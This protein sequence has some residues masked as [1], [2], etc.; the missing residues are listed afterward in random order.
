[1]TIGKLFHVAH[2][3]EDLAPLDA[4]YD[5]VFAPVRGVMD[6]HYAAR[7]QRLGSLLVIGD[8]IV[9]AI[10]ERRPRGG[11]PSDRPVPGQVRPALA[12]GG[13]VLR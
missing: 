2:I 11:H 7:V 9:E 12:L 1:M 13:L 10:A 3:T 5:R 6:G 4:W 8:A